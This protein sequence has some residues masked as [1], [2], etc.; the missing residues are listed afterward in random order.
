M[1]FIPA[2]VRQAFRRL[3][4]TPVLSLGAVTI[5]AIGIG[6][7]VV[8]VD[9]LDRLLL[10]VP[11]HVTDPDRVS[12]VY[13]GWPGGS[14]TDRMGYATY[15]ALTTLHDEIDASATYFPRSCRSDAGRTHDASRPSPTRPSTLPCSAFSR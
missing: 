8:M 11:A 14:R 12:R 1:G 10:R 4:A 5:L 15:E 13:L 7:A 2:D 6:S 3:A 9:I